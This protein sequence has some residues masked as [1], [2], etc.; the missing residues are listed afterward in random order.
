MVKDSGGPDLEALTALV[1]TR[2]GSRSQ[3][4][5]VH[6]LPPKVRE[7]I[8]MLDAIE[9]ATPTAVSRAAVRRVLTEEWGLSD[10]LTP[11]REA[12]GR[13]FRGECGC[14]IFGTKDT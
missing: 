4:C 11:S 5:W 12:L 3:L 10:E 13:H 1:T 7:W 6:F 9:V 14:G 2:K 8:S